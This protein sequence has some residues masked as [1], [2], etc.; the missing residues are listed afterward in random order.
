M[1]SLRSVLRRVPVTRPYPR[2]RVRALLAQRDGQQL[3]P[4][5]LATDVRPSVRGKFLFVGDEK[6][7]I[8]GVT[9][10]TFRPRADGCEFPEPLEVA[11]DF[12]LMAEHG[13]NTVRT[14]TVPPRWLLDT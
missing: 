7:Y 6:L 12:A 9:Y 3:Q 5:D 14:Y 11:T 8:R 13:I 10:G 4:G 2:E 1:N